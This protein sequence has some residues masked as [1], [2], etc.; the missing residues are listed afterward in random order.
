MND[1]LNQH[2]IGYNI[3]KI[4]D[5]KLYHNHFIRLT[6]VLKR[7]HGTEAVKKTNQCSISNYKDT[8]ITI[9]YWLRPK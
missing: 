5:Y 3:F 4:L 1:L 6:I 7:S 2:W 8:Y 9:K